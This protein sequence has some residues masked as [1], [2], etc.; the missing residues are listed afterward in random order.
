M[1]LVEAEIVA[2]T[3]ILDGAIEQTKGADGDPVF[4]EVDYRIVNPFGDKQIQSDVYD[5]LAKHDLIECSGME[6]RDGNKMAEF[7]CITPKGLEA[8]KAATGVY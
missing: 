1:V 4:E 6:D 3:A 8:L 5:N 2:L 7:V